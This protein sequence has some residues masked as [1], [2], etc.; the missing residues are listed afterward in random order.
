MAFDDGE[1][2]SRLAVKFSSVGRKL[3]EED[4]TNVAFQN[5]WNLV[6]LVALD[7]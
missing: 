1:Y 4:P 6:P 3:I 5:F 2:A 7:S